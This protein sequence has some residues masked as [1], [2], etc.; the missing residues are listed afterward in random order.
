MRSVAELGEALGLGREEI[1]PA[2]AS[3]GK[4]AV[5]VVRGRAS[6]A[7]RGKLILVTG[8]TP[9]RHG[10]GKTVTTIG[11][12][13]ALVRHGRRSVACLRQPSMGPVFGVK[14]G[15]T[16]GGRSTVEPSASINLGFTGDIHAVASAHNLLSALID[17]HL[18]HGNA[19]DIDPARTGWPR[20]LDVEDRALR[21][22][23]TWSK[24]GGRVPARDGR[25]LITAASE[26]MAVLALARDYSDL[27][28]RLGRMLLGRTR[29]GK[30]VRTG[31]LAAAGAMAALLRDAL[32][33]NVAQSSEG[34]PVLI[35]AG[36]FANIAHGTASR[37]S[38]ELALGC[39]EYT[40]V[41]AGFA[42][43]LG[44]EKFVDIVTPIL[45]VDVDAAVLVVTLPSL[46]YHGGA[47]D[48]STEHPDRSA[49]ERGLPNLGQH[50]SI[51][52]TFQ[53]PVVVAINRHP[54]DDPQETERVR[55]YCRER[56]VEAVEHR[57]FSEGGAGA[58]ALAAA[59]EAAAGL[60]RHSHP[61]I[62][63]GADPVRQVETIVRT[64][65][66]GAGAEWTE[67]ALAELAVLQ[68]LGEVSGPV[69]MAK[70]P[71][72]I[73]DDPKKRG[74]PEGFVVQVRHVDRSAGAGFTVVRLGSVE[75]MPGLPARPASEHIDLDPDGR[76]VG[77]S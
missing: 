11:L 54:S 67:E 40:V 8:M 24:P 31:D 57:L 22:V 73:S 47:A 25:F 64:I 17:N 46:R 60:G 9:T 77:L 13:D 10:E 49:L 16:G 20:T 59:V 7:R 6:S 75:T 36:P 58:L 28:Q 3:A 32:E 43:E 37:L 21:Q 74:R 34:N 71:L 51:L 53:V 23:Q 69:C 33:P 56:G 61:A 63:P 39:A 62:D 4:V 35:H 50:L 18:Y 30:A 55:S 44:G 76:I 38:I 70:T 42:T 12:A 14:G 19:L 68:E 27:K 48:G 29:S 5:S 15:A 52:K 65:Y 26:V 2:G 66:G 72:S 41:E 1:H 45:G